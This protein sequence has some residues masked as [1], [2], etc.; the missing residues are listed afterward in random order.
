[1]VGA[2]GYNQRLH[3]L[4]RKVF[5]PNGGPCK[6]E[7]GP[8]VLERFNDWQHGYLIVDVRKDKILGSY[9]AVD[10]PAAGDAIPTAPAKPFDRFEITL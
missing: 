8:E 7:D 1:V 6:F 5:D 9:I 10:D 4:D 3:V 2:G